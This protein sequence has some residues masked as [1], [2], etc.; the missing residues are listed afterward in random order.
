V[1]A[2]LLLPLLL[3]LAG[4]AAAQEERLFLGNSITER[5]GYVDILAEELPYETIA[6]A[7]CGATTTW[8]WTLD[9]PAPG[10]HCAFGSE[11]SLYALFV[12]PWAPLSTVYVLLGTNDSAFHAWL[13]DEIPVHPDEYAANLVALVE[14]LQRDGATAVV[15]I[16]PPDV[17][18]HAPERNQRLAGYRER[19]REICGDRLG[20]V[21]GPDLSQILTQ[22]EDFT[23]ALHP[24]AQGHAKIAAALLDCD[25]P[26]WS[27]RVAPAHEQL[28][29]RCWTGLD[30]SL[31]APATE[32]WSERRD[33]GP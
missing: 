21:C 5:E 25:A 11:A 27:Q 23:D 20:V 19:I 32:D 28:D 13:W 6:R 16:S 30:P 17:S 24:S 31:Y 3:L 14:A 7:A 10:F 9:G 26:G 8:Q 18:A 12:E 15:L 33:A 29:G 1:R 22:P 4:V 2:L